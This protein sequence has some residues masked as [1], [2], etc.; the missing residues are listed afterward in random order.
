MPHAIRTW[1]ALLLWVLPLWNTALAQG[2]SPSDVNAAARA[3]L[4]ACID[5]IN[6]EP[7]GL[8]ELEKRCPEL[9][10]ALQAAEIRPL[11]IASSRDRLDRRSLIQLAALLRPPLGGAPA[12]SKLQPFLRV[13]TAA[14]APRSWWGRAWDWVLA[15][16]HLKQQQ[17][18]ASQSWLT[19][20]AQAMDGSQ[21]LWRAILWGALIAL[22]V[23]VAI[24]VRREVRAMGSRSSDERANSRASAA[25]GATHSQLA[26]LR[27]MPLAQRPA[28]L[29]AL[30]TARLVAAGRLPPDRSLTHREVVR[31][32]VLEDVEQ[33][34]DL[35]SLARLSERQL[36]SGAA[37]PAQGLEELL[38][39]GEDLYTTGW[40]HALER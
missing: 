10:A 27:Q 28:R 2:V 11:I 30:L 22:A 6:D 32:V 36:Y 17:P 18:D 21:W 33:R 15:H 24:L 13:P 3:A 38:A 20:F 29:F 19:A 40:G 14:V 8:S 23:A 9:P 7:T 35:E 31:R 5:R 12:V 26:L 37:M 16:L 4:G 1:P 39:R 34:H 25:V